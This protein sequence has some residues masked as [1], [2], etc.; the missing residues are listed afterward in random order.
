M[1]RQPCADERL[2]RLQGIGVDQKGA[3]YRVDRRHVHNSTNGEDTCFRD[4]LR[5]DEQS[6]T[7]AWGAKRTFETSAAGGGPDVRQPDQVEWK[8][9]RGK[10]AF[11]WTRPPEQPQ[12]L[13]LKVSTPKVDP[14][15]PPRPS[16]PGEKAL[17][18]AR[19]IASLIS[20]AEVQLQMG[21]AEK[22]IVE[23]L[24]TAIP[25]LR[26]VKVNHR[27]G[28]WRAETLAKLRS[29][30]HALKLNCIPKILA[31]IE[32]LY[33]T[34]YRPK[35]TAEKKGP[36][37]TAEEM[38]P[39]RETR[40]RSVGERADEDGGG[41]GADEGARQKLYRRISQ[42]RGPALRRCPDLRRGPKNRKN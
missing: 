35:K 32:E 38:G 1:A 24:D 30:L 14:S 22:V 10:V 34:F 36:M 19:I 11:V 13:A 40:N 3:E 20:L 23:T 18:R 21:Y 12:E 41:E 2:Q 25:F 4:Y 9:K 27:G 7:V 39:M 42:H 28:G 15:S 26:Q 6:N 17:A 29:M 16:D 8:D 37:K 31:T 33:S 5:F